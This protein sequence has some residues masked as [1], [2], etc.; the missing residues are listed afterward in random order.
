VGA[1]CRSAFRYLN[2]LDVKE[3]EKADKWVLL[4]LRVETGAVISG[5]RPRLIAEHRAE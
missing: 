1:G 2:K 5:L 3:D 4:V